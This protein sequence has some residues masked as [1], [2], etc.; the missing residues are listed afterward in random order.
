M[1]VVVDDVVRRVCGEPTLFVRH[2]AKDQP[3]NDTVQ[4]I[5]RYSKTK[6]SASGGGLE[7]DPAQCYVWI[8]VFGGNFHDPSEVEGMEGRQRGD[9]GGGGAEGESEGLVVVDTFEE[10]S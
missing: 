5:L 2:Y 8:D 3:F 9:K 6:S 7:L 4:E 1:A 10:L